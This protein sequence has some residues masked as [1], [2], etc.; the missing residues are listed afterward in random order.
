MSLA[1]DMNP[2]KCAVTL[3]HSRPAAATALE[4]AARH[5]VVN[6]ETT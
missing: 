5:A 1:A 6:L 2:V 4:R 3:R